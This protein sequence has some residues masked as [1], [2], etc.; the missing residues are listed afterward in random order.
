MAPSMKVVSPLEF[1]SES[2]GIHWNSIQN[3][4]ES[5]GIPFRIQ[6][7]PLEYEIPTIPADSGWNSNIPLESA[8][9]RQNPCGRVKYWIS[10]PML[11]GIE[12]ALMCFKAKATIMPLLSF[13]FASNFNMEGITPKDNESTAKTM[14]K[15]KQ[16]VKPRPVH[17]SAAKVKEMVVEDEGG[18]QDVGP[19]FNAAKHVMNNPKVHLN[20]C[21]SQALC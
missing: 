14:P 4:V 11:S 18:K 13:D 21:K 6:R 9:I 1:H 8:G 17:R 20:V 2:G 3:P 19:P 12:K 16:P 7:N 10:Q 5:I 15:G